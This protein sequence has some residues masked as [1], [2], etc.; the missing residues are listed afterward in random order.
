MINDIFHIDAISRDRVSINR[1]PVDRLCYESGVESEDLETAEGRLRWARKKAGYQS[2]ALFAERIGMGAVTYRSYENGQVKFA[3]HAVRFGKALGVGADWLI[4]GGAIPD[5][6]ERHLS[7][8][9]AA[10]VV[11]SDLNIAMIRQVDIT[12]AMGDG[13]VIA[14][15]PDTGAVPFDRNFLSMLGVRAPDA[16][17]ICRGEGDSMAPTLFGGDIVMIDTSRNRVTMQDQ[18]WALAVAGAGMI[19]RLRPLPNNK[20]LVLSDNPLVPDQEYEVDDVYVVGR[21]IWIGRQM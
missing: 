12:Y 19:K 20:V 7:T 2:A 21:V 5:G 4:A 1:I 8:H 16:V 6:A 9:A 15:Y 3:K 18:I 14:D 10:H 13:S 11:A 17:F